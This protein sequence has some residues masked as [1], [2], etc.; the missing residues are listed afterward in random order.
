MAVECFVILLEESALQGKFKY[1]V[2]ATTRRR[3]LHI[4]SYPL[5]LTAEIEKFSDR[6]GQD[7]LEGGILLNPT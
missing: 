2:R 5:K 7:F 1:T 3:G 6:G 4:L